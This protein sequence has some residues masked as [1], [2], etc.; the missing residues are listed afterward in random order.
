MSVSFRSPRPRRLQSYTVRKTDLTSGATRSL[1]PGQRFALSF[2]SLRPPTSGVGLLRLHVPAVTAPAAYSLAIG[3]KKDDAAR[4]Q[5]LL[6]KG[7]ELL[8]PACEAGDSDACYTL[9]LEYQWGTFKL[10]PKDTDKAA[11]LSKK[12]CML[13]NQDGCYAYVNWH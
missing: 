5:A 2:G 13:G 6:T 10:L 1:G 7:I 4:G 12:A 11:K 8:P 3:L 9:A